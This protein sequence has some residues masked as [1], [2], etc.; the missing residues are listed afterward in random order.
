MAQVA[1][2]TNQKGPQTPGKSLCDASQRPRSRL[3]RQETSSQLS[4]ETR[5]FM[6]AGLAALSNLST[7]KATWAAKAS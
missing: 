4:M 7:I 3:R 5:V 1:Y 6:G 2:T